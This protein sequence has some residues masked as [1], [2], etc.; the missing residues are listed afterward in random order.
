MELSKS[1]IKVTRDI[2][3]LAGSH[4][5][6]EKVLVVGAAPFAYEIKNKMVHY[7]DH[8]DMIATIPFGARVILYGTFAK[9]FD[10][11]LI[12]RLMAKHKTRYLLVQ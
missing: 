1:T 7:I 2:F 8:P 5:E 4:R 9:R 12:Q 3:I 6:Y 10:W 11:P